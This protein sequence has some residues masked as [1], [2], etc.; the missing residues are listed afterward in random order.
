MNDNVQMK[1]Y[2]AIGS[3]FEKI[4]FSNISQ[5]QKYNITN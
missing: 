2:D 1:K 5:S 4:V 3:E